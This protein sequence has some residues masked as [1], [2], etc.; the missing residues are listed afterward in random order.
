M[1]RQYPYAIAKP[2]PA[3]RLALPLLALALLG[4][5]GAHGGRADAAYSQC[6]QQLLTRYGEDTR[7]K[8]KRTRDRRG[9]TEVTVRVQAGA[10]S[11]VS[12]CTVTRDGAVSFTGPDGNAVA[13]VT[14][15]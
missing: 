9:A 13:A 14:S 10:E 2:S 6:K 8:L 15:S 12:T 3:R 1:S 5:A 7:V 11:F 4:S